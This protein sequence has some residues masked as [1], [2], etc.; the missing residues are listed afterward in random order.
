MPKKRC[1]ITQKTERLY[2]GVAG[3]QNNSFE[4]PKADPVPS[5]PA[6]DNLASLRTWVV[7]DHGLLLEEQLVSLIPFTAGGSQDGY[8]HPAPPP[9]LTH[10]PPS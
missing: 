5:S 9:R 10:F 1:E 7:G 2:S 6:A 3:G 4:L 8:H